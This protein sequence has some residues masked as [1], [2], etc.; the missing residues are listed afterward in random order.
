[1]GGG[2]SG[3]SKRFRWG[4]G[5]LKGLGL[6]LLCDLFYGFC[7]VYMGFIRFFLVFQWF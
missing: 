2:F 1:M 3:K 7:K 6:R 5:A 4:V